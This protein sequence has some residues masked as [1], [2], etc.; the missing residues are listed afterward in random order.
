[1]SGG[2]TITFVLLCAAMAAN[3]IVVVA[4]VVTAAASD[5][6][7]VRVMKGVVTVGS[8]I[9]AFAACNETAVAVMV[10]MPLTD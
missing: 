10:V 1:M 3:S 2:R 6:V 5:V 9:V 4:V 7:S 8:V